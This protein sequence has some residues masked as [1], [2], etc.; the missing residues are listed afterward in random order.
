MSSLQIQ[1]IQDLENRIK[2][3]I[4]EVIKWQLKE[5]I[6]L[7]HKPSPQSWSALECL[8]HLNR[9]GDFYIP[10]ISK[11]LN[12][13]TKEQASTFKSTWLGNYFH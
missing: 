12:A 10:E 4:Q 1:L 9:Y 7:N 6:L 11:R 13:A 3:S 5:Q 8:E 2:E